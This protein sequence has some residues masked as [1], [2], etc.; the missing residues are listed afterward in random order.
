MK[1][2]EEN[3]NFPG[4]IQKVMIDQPL[5][6]TTKN[7]FKV[8]IGHYLLPSH[9]R[10]ENFSDSKLLSI[11]DQFEVRKLGMVPIGL[12]ILDNKSGLLFFADNFR[13]IDYNS[14][15]YVENEIGMAFLNKLWDYYWTSTQTFKKF[16]R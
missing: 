15:F 12:G 8:S 6:R 1:K 5:E 10:E 16:P 13:Q 7:D 14:M 11:H 9:A 4:E 3:F 2:V